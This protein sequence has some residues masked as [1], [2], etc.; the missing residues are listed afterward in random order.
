M[1]R[2]DKELGTEE[3]ILQVLDRCDTIRL[4]FQGAEYPYIVPLSFGWEMAGGRL[5]LYVH[6]AK[7]GLRHELLAE[8]FRVCV[9]ADR[10]EG[11]MRVEDGITCRYE[12][13]IGFGRVENVVGEEAANGLKLI[14]QHADYPDDPVPECVSEYTSVW[15]ITIS[16]MTGKRSYL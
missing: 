14:L 3:E 13:V 2:N 1:R 11:F 5:Y 16:Q 10:N 7:A 6:G 8:D 15:K 9:E 12:S 4:G